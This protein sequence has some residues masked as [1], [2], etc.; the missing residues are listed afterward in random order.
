MVNQTCPECNTSSPME[1]ED[2]VVWR[3]IGKMA[4]ERAIADLFACAK[5]GCEFLILKHK[6]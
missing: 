6:P 2:W 5:C 3:E 4:V 1:S